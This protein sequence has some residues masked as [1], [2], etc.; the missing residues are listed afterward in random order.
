MTAYLAA[1]L[2]SAA[3]VV[4]GVA[5]LVFLLV[6][7]APGDPVEVMAGERARLGPGGPAVSV[8]CPGLGGACYSSD[9]DR[10]EGG[11]GRGGAAYRRWSARSTAIPGRVP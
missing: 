7:L 3:L 9:G 6:H 10:P 4:L 11:A 8:P 5:C 2:A 1:R